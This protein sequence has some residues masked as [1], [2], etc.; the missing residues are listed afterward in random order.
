MDRDTVLLMKF[1]SAMRA[2]RYSRGMTQMKLAEKVG[3]SLQAIGNI[4]RGQA[5]PTL[6]MVY[7][8]AMALDMS[9]KDLVP[10]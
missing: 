6:L 8:I 4:E 5:N 9:I 1:G 3:C 7:K 10:G 2:R